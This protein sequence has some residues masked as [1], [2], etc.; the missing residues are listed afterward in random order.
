MFIGHF[1]A[2][3]GAK[4]VAPGV[5]LGALFIAA[6]F[7]DLLWPTLL[8]LGVERVQIVPGATT[9]TPLVFEY[10]PVS[11]SLLAVLGWALVVGLGHFALNRSRKGA[12]VLAALVLSHWG[13]DFIVH[14]PD[15][16]LLPG[17]DTMVGLNAW[18]SLPLT[19]AIEVTIFG[20]GVWLYLRATKASDAI[21]RWALW[22]LVGFLC[23]VYAANLF[24]APPPSVEAIAW[25]GHLQW[26]IVLW[27][28]W[29]DKHRVIFRHVWTAPCLQGFI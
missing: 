25:L 29:I 6:Q 24:G 23:V 19:L 14:Q 22:G 9:V 13:L 26:L 8:L 21:G 7:I 5:S 4:A 3:F 1:G 17:G 20:G 2:G 12:L 16:P 11:H 10:Y 15:L 18:S 28:F 27:G